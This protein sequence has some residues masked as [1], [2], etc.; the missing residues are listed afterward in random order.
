MGD[1]LH[2]GKPFRYRLKTNTTP[3]PTQPSICLG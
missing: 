2:T 1:G 3:R